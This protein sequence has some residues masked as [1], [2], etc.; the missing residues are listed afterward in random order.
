MACVLAL[1]VKNIVSFWEFI[2]SYGEIRKF[3]GYDR[4]V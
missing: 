3:K 4:V 2:N 1:G